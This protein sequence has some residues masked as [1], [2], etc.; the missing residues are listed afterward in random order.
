MGGRA[1]GWVAIE[2]ATSEVAVGNEECVFVCLG[3]ILGVEVE[4]GRKEGGIGVR[5]KNVWCSNGGAAEWGTDAV[6]ARGGRDGVC[7]S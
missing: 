7:A 6:H 1:C 5:Y 2:V 4:R 3:R